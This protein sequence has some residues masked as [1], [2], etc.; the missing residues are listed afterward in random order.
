MTLLTFF[1]SITDANIAHLQD[2]P[3]ADISEKLASGKGKFS[4][5]WTFEETSLVSKCKLDTRGLTDSF[6]MFLTIIIKVSQ[7]F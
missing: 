6:K 3:E 5:T 1:L 2:L 7:I 4:H